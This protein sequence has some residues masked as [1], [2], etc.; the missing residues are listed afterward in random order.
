MTDVIEYKDAKQKIKLEMSYFVVGCVFFAVLAIASIVYG[1]YVLFVNSYDWPRHSAIWG[2]GGILLLWEMGRAFWQRTPL[3]PDFR[4]ITATD[5]PELFRLVR[6]VTSELHLS[7]VTKVYVCPDVMAAVF[8]RPDLKGLFSVSQRSLVIGMGL[9]TQLDD[10]ELRAVL[11]HEFGHYVQEDMEDSA[12]V[13]RIGLFARDFIA[14]RKM[15]KIGVWEMQLKNQSVLFSYFLDMVC[16]RVNRSY[17]TLSR[18]MEYEAD[19]VAVRFMG[20][21]ALQKALVHVAWLK[22]NYKVL[23]WGAA[24]LKKQ[25][26]CVDNVYAALALACRIREYEKRVFGREI[27]MRLE[28]LGELV[29]VDG[30]VSAVVRNAF[31]M[32]LLP[33]RPMEM[34][35]CPYVQFVSWMEHGFKVYEHLQR[36]KR[37]VRVE[38]HMQ[39]HLHRLPFV[40]GKYHIVLDGKSIGDGNFRKGYTLK[41]HTFAGQHVLSVAAISGIMSVPLKFEVEAGCAYRIEMDFKLHYWQAVWEIFPKS[42]EKFRPCDRKRKAQ[43]SL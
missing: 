23:L 34:K 14:I 19:D 27:L 38:I 18:R 6:E 1:Y 33:F 22:Y 2:A 11:Y 15:K 3:P 39:P 13:Y 40:E 9:L 16:S 5:Y 32:E 25:G 37:A 42:V 17:A 31:P 10:D 36:L 24:R 35:V 20:V 8:I 41:C 30:N 7:E 4:E 12:M 28:R 26:V 43:D 21:A 29:P